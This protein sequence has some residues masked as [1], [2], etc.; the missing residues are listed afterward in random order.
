MHINELESILEDERKNVIAVNKS[1]ENPKKKAIAVNK[2]LRNPNT[3][4]SILS[5]TKRNQTQKT[6]IASNRMR[7]QTIFEGSEALR[8][9]SSSRLAIL[10]RIFS[11]LSG[12]PGPKLTRCDF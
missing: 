7:M 11:P 6:K 4:T 1:L 8:C 2:S 5:I 10:R 12:K 9:F 3:V